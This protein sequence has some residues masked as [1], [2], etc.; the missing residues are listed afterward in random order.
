[1]G[2]FSAFGFAIDC[3]A[4]LGKLLFESQTIFLVSPNAP[5]ALKLS[6]KKAGDTFELN[7]QKLTIKELY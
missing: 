2:L 3:I 4:G 5:I 7:N 6:G 1:M